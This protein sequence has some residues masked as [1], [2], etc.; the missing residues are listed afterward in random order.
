MAIRVTARGGRGGGRFGSRGPW[1]EA[2]SK[3]GAV[4]FDRKGNS[5]KP[6]N[7]CPSKKNIDVVMKS[8]QVTQG[9]GIL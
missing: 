9:K 7:G 2:G 5:N 8:S 1:V 4:N 6:M 3:G